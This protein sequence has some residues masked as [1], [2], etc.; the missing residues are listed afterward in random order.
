ME[1]IAITG[2]ACRFPGAPSLSS[3]WKMLSEGGHGIGLVPADR[4][5][6]DAFYDDDPKAAGKICSRY[7]GFIEN[8]DGF[9]TEFFGISPREAVQMDPQQ[10]ILM[11]LAYEALEDAGIAPTALRG[12]DTAVYIG[13]MSNDYLRH[14]T[15]DNY[16]RIDVHTGGGAGFC[17]LANRLSYQF[18]FNGPSMAVDSACSSSLVSIYQGCQAL[19]TGQSEL[20]I[21][22][23][24]NIILDP[25]NNVFYSK[26]G[27]LAPD[28]LCKTFAKSANGI[29]RGEG[30]GLVVLKH[31]CDAL[32]D[33]DFIYAVIR[34]GAV[35]HDGR[36]NGVTAPNRWAQEKLL[37]KA[38]QHAQVKGN[39]LDYVELHGTGTYIGD[40]IEAKALGAELKRDDYKGN[41]LVGSVKSNIGHL[42]AAAGVAG[43]IKLALCLHH[44]ALPPSLW[45][46]EPNPVIDFAELPLEVNTTYRPWPI[47]TDHNR[48]LNAGLSGFGLGGTNAHLVLQSAPVRSNL[49]KDLPMVQTPLLLVISASNE[50]ALRLQATQFHDLLKNDVDA[51]AICMTS[52]RRRDLHDYRLN[53]LG[54]DRG[55]LCQALSDYLKG[56]P[57]TRVLSARFK[58]N[59]QRLQ[60][61]LPNSLR[62][63]LERLALWLRLAP[64]GRIAWKA[65]Q[66]QLILSGED[67]LPTLEKL[68]N[69]ALPEDDQ[70]RR[71]WRFAIQYAMLQQILATLPSS[72]TI[73][74]EGFSQLAASCASGALSLSDALDWLR[75]GL[76]SKAPET[77]DYK[78]LCE[79][80]G[81]A[82][83]ELDNLK[84]EAENAEW[85]NRLKPKNGE[86]VV[87]I[88]VN[89]DAA[90]SHIN[91][92][93]C[94]GQDE[95]DYGYLFARLSL[96]CNLQMSSLADKRFVR[97][98]SYPW[99]K[100]SY[101]IP[102]PLFIDS[103]SRTAAP[104]SEV[105]SGTV[106]ESEKILTDSVR[107]R[108][109]AKNAGDQEELLLSYLRESLG[110]ALHMEAAA[111]DL[112]KPL[113]T[114]GI[115]S[116][117][118]VEVKNRIE[119]DL[120]ITIP[121][122]KFL[123]GFAVNDFAEFIL[124]EL[125]NIAKDSS[126][127]VQTVSFS[128][129]SAIAERHG[130]I[131]DQVA[132][133]SMEQVN[134]MLL[135]FGKGGIK[136]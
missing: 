63:D 113:N 126:R 130:D 39:Q 7:G 104:D 79:C 59:K 36:S 61:A 45:F 34:G 54:R 40:P 65:C 66:E 72:L 47:G 2:M 67:C 32:R 26:G 87:T 98:P 124:N 74:P 56:I 118:A 117:T 57:S 71:L 86:R 114:M 135:Q 25:T 92:L 103:Q 42:E 14:Q 10:R 78:F 91:A 136:R 27:L 119:R 38:W 35:N 1:P 55:S 58:P 77:G 3:Y 20:A 18:D 16:R 94:L 73:V 81:G 30:A 131:S 62:M 82:N 29:G 115:D 109:Y 95:N 96:L 125:G 51:A 33:E 102:S 70:C 43:F 44:R 134:E 89:I 112:R 21:A 128:A 101:W 129:D 31:E 80:E 49:E 23:G 28:G 84:W 5:D 19:W 52:L 88:L 97:L 68:K 106:V 122:V 76:D 123:D 99:Q 107:S 108:L 105:Q 132:A 111:I 100:K 110:I 64:F 50:E 121:V 69:A 22:G 11:E 41:C 83:P 24:I 127:P 37:R 8:I 120:H 85:L 17:M 93:H 9:D 53:V 60:V 48:P 15:A 12:S 4:W 13:V 116:L 75:R 133:M 6:A 46:D 90:T